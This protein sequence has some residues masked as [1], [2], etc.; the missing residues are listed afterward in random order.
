MLKHSFMRAGARLYVL[1]R[2]VMTFVGHTF[3]GLHP[4]TLHADCEHAV[5]GHSGSVSDV[6]R[7]LHGGRHVAERGAEFF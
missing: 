1:G 3:V 2:G 4:V 5:Y 7:D 6:G